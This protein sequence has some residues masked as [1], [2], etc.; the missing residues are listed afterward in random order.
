MSSKVQIANIALV[1][2]LGM[3]RIN[4][5]DEPNSSA[6]QINTIYDVA[7]QEI[8]S[9]WKWGF[10]TRRQR[11]AILSNNDRPE[12][13]FK[14]ALPGNMIVLNWIN[15]PYSA[16]L[17]VTDR[18]VMDTPR[19]VEGGFVYSDVPEATAEFVFDQNDAGSYPPKFI[20]AFAAL[21][22]SKVA[23]PLTET[24]NKVEF[25]L[26]RYETLLDEAK[27]ADVSLSP[28]VVVVKS[29]DWSAR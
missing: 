6:I 20:Q 27:V 22:A 12:W 21:L 16:K 4:S 2:Y 18:Q 8:L 28:P 17:A 1:S 9:E 11:L 26:T 7:R 29:N 10:A 24:A 25:A 23:M 14:Y 5:L 3:T 15:D 13:A 19:E